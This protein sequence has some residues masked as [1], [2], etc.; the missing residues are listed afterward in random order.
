MDWYPFPES[1]LFINGVKIERGL[2][3]KV[4]DKAGRSMVVKYVS[5]KSPLVASIRMVSGPWYIKIFTGS[6]S[7]KELN[8][9]KTNV[10][11]KYRIV[12]YPAFLGTFVRYVFRKMRI[13]DFWI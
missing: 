10:I 7:F 13:K 11:F 12:S 5:Y 8:E 9:N 2:H 6:W 3:L 1:Y 4:V